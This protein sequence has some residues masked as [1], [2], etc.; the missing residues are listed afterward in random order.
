MLLRHLSNSGAIKQLYIHLSPDFDTL[1]IF[2][3]IVSSRFWY[4][5]D[6]PQYCILRISILL[7][8]S[9]IL[10]PPDFDTLVIFPNIVSSRFW[11][12][13]DLPQYC[14]LQ[15][16]ILLWSSPILYP[17]DFDTL[18]IFPNIVSSRFWYSCDLP[19]YCIL[20]ILILLW[21]SPILYPPDFDTLVI[22][23][24][25]V[26][27]RFWYSCDLPQYCILQILILLWSSPILYPPDFDTLVIPNI[28]SSRFWY[29][30]DLPQ[31][32]I[33][34]VLMERHVPSCT[35]PLYMR[36]GLLSPNVYLWVNML[37]E[38][39]VLPDKDIY[40]IT[41]SK[42]H[43]WIT[44]KAMIGWCQWAWPIRNLDNNLRDN[45]ALLVE[46]CLIG[47]LWSCLAVFVQH[48]Q[49]WLCCLVSGAC[50]SVYA[51]C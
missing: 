3:N 29:S 42:C 8:S 11:Y 39:D 1:V 7:W 20:Q 17:P 16:L 33:L 32:C 9:P 13:C 48:Y 10:Y 41:L 28:V 35:G 21:S 45:F 40:K 49:A 5:C 43:V 24:N 23:P 44:S 27:S 4:S 15:I 38:S 26:S 50:L 19:Q 2:P 6:L 30:C 51:S 25:I 22:F 12:S 47:Y 46:C 18:V 36:L 34:P 14:I 37:W 31:Y